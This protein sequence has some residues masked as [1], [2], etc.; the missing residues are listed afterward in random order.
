MKK[1]ITYITILFFIQSTAFGNSIFST[2]NP[3]SNNGTEKKEKKVNKNK[4]N[5]NF[6]KKEARGLVHDFVQI[7]GESE[8][9]FEKM[10]EITI[11]DDNWQK[12]NKLFFRETKDIDLPKVKGRQV[13]AKIPKWREALNHFKQS[14]LISKNVISAYQ[15]LT[16][17]NQHFT[18]LTPK[19]E[20]APNIKENVLDEYMPVFTKL[21]KEKG[22]C[23]GYTYYLKYTLNYEN[24]LDKAISIGEIG[25]PICQKQLNDKK[26]PKWLDLAFRKDFVKAKT[27]K[28]VRNAKLKSRIK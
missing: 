7:T 22:Y 19:T 11:Q 28:R 12:A 9:N 6:T 18:V 25:Y 1:F 23:Y 24:N 26:I 20:Y 13:K 27:I 5:K 8:L 17:V 2:E 15:G 10:L 4:S 14:V 16:I 21:L 3:F